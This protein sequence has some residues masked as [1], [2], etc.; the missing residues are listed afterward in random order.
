MTGVYHHAWLDCV[1]KKR[2]KD[3][4]HEDT[5]PVNDPPLVEGNLLH[6]FLRNSSFCLIA[7]IQ[8]NGV[9]FGCVKERLW[10]FMPKFSQTSPV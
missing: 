7:R 6:K 4:A 8:Q 1:N 10:V 9:S 3:R 5:E 2:M